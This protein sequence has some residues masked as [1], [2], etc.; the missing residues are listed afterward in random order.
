MPVVLPLPIYYDSLAKLDADDENVILAALYARDQALF[1]A[2]T[3]ILQTNEDLYTQFN[4]VGDLTSRI[5][6]LNQTINGI[7]AAFN[8]NLGL[9]G[10]PTDQYQGFAQLIADLKANLGYAETLSATIIRLS[11]IQ[12]AIVP[13][14]VAIAQLDDLDSLIQIKLDYI[15]GKF[16]VDVNDDILLV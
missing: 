1:T 10:T 2:L 15:Y 9:G 7:L 12:A 11:D 5:I 14:N 16:N 8:I 4:L 6:A 13:V 3:T